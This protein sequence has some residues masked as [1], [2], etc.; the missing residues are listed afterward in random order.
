MEYLL[1]EFVIYVG[2]AA[3]LAGQANARQTF[4]SNKDI[5]YYN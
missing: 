4:S 1:K 3:G 5:Y 2:V